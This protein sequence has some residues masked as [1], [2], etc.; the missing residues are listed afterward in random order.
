M[1]PPEDRI[2]RTAEYLSRFRLHA[3]HACHCTDL[4]SKM[5]LAEVAPVKEVGVGLRVEYE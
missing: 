1:N 2:R 4:M 5:R 3:L